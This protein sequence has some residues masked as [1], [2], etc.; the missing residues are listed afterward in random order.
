[1]SDDARIL[2]LGAGP[3]GLGAAS[4]LHELGHANFLVLEQE[5]H[6]GGLASSFRDAQGFVWD[7]GGHIQFSHY[8]YFDRL[9]DLALGEGWIHHQRESY[10]SM[11]GRFI[12]YPLQ[13][14]LRHLPREVMA[15]CVLGL[16]RVG[17]NHSPRTRNFGEWIRASFGEGIAR[18]F[19][20]PYNAKVW[21]H[22]LEIMSHSWTGERVAKVSLERVLENVLLEKDDVKWGPN[23][24][25]RFPLNGGTGAV[26]RA[27]AALLP[28][29]TV[30]YGTR[31][32]SIDA[33]GRRARTADGV[34]WEYDYLISSL[35]L[36]R[37]CCLIGA[38]VLDPAA[39]LR[40]SSVHVVGVGFAG[41]PPESL[42]QKCWIYFP[43][44]ACS[45]HR[46]TLFSRYSPNNVPDAGRYWS[47]MAEISESEF[48]PVDRERLLE[49]TL[50]DFYRIGLVQRGD[51]IASAW[52]HL[53]SYGYP[54]PTTDRDEI[55]SCV[56]PCLESMGIF[57]RGRFGGWKYEVS[58]QDHCCMQG[59]EVAE[60]LLRGAAE[61]T[62]PNPEAV[63]G[64]RGPLPLSDLTNR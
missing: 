61:T 37:L 39:R 58:N 50:E 20:L 63:N 25:F 27:V 54:I 31:V 62:Y 6:P 36:D 8:E 53:A 14:N 48:K 24:T 1:M 11:C 40:H 19:L 56:Q 21:A 34:E 26:W 38:T 29:G 9:M 42:T 52:T 2:I 55:L 32:E 51:R 17:Q 23:E 47:L 22:P 43:E 7:V 41:S 13:S 16:L 3:T 12:P 18:H 30:R 59:V 45:F 64:R 28:A 15:E 10:I 60:H 46:V 35:P 57:S 33:G 49:Q 5:N 4:R 44:A